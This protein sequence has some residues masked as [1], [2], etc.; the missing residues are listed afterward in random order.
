MTDWGLEEVMMMRLANGNFYPKKTGCC[1][2]NRP[3]SGWQKIG[4]IGNKNHSDYILGQIQKVKSLNFWC[5][6][7]LSEK[8]PVLSANLNS[9]L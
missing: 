8:H 2:Q 3:G 6:S 4:P 5:N 1:R 9:G 7:S